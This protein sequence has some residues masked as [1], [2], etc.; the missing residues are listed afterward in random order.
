M[1]EHLQHDERSVQLKL[2]SRKM[3]HNLNNMLFIIDAYTDMIKK[4]QADPE[5][6]AN[7]RQIEAALEQTQGIM[8]DWRTEADKIV[9]DP[10][11]DN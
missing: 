2:L 4:D 11:E 6:L 3:V 9:P 1:P 10:K 7:I 8:R 5:L